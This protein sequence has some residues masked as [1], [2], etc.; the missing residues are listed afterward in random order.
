MNQRY[1]RADGTGVPIETTAVVCRFKGQ[2]AHLVFVR[3]CT[4]REMAELE[5]AELQE[6]LQQAQ[7][8]ESVGQLA[9]GVA[10]DFNNILMVQKGYCEL[11]KL[12]LREGDPLA[13]SL[14]HIEASAERATALT[15]QLLA[16]SRKQ[17]LQPTVLDLNILVESLD[18]M[19]HRLVGEDVDLV[20]SLASEPALVKADSVQLEQVLVNLAANARDAMPRGGSLAIAVS[21]VEIDDSYGESHAGVEPGP[22]VML[23]VSDTGSGMDAETKRRIFEPFYTTKG[24]GRGTGLGLS[25]VYGIVHQSGGSIWVY[26]EPGN[27][28]TFRVYLPQA[29]GEPEPVAPPE[30]GAAGGKGQL[31]LIVEDEPSLRSLAS[32][33]IERLEYRAV[34]AANGGEAL[35]LVEEEGLRPD[36][37][38]TDVIMPG[39]SG[40]VLVER[41]RKTLPDL[42]VIFMSGYPD[43]AM[44]NHG[45]ID[46]DISF[47]QKPFSMSGLAAKVRA[48]LGMGSS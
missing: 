21:P 38:L 48:T 44:A 16:F 20:M 31:I 27:G 34:E 17:T 46:S 4:E 45:I 35:I 30:V 47:L 41:L 15:R 26:S 43:S 33:M 5:R 12:E 42:R 29:E 37:L 28:T 32:L 36:L 40:S 18:D 11:M 14:A 1:L 6:Q 13:A 39:M 8:M 24:E 19:L 7:K 23:S 3:D 10:H 22:Y 25:T 2:A 9:G